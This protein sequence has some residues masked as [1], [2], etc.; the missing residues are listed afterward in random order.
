MKIHSEGNGII[1]GAI[2]LFGFTEAYLYFA[3]ENKI[4]F[5]L[6]LPVVL[7]LIGLTIN[8]FR[9]PK[10]K[11]PH[12]AKGKVIASAD[13][14]IVVIEKVFEPEVLK[15]E[16]IMVSTFMSATNVH[17]NWVPVIGEVKVVKHHEGNFMA[18]YLPKSSVENERSTV[19]LETPEKHKVLLRQVA[20]ALAQRI[21]TYIEE[22][23][24][25]N[26]DDVLGFI[27]FGS[28]VDLY[29]PLGSE[30]HVK[31]DQKV[32]ATQTLIASLPTSCAA[33]E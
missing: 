27:K 5:W 24:K 3:F 6:V 33:N 9:I 10:R 12:E 30:V 23:E 13:G 7:V 16:C 25:V 18:A 19:L 8:F 32:T 22:G 26:P 14:H 11:C 17:A 29:L 2:L 31:L 20:G 4:A 15:T 21:V 28:R 1:I